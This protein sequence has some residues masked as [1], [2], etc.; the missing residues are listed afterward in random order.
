M[1]SA[2]PRVSVIIPTY[3]RADFIGEAVESVLKQGFVD[4]ELIVIDDG[5]TDNTRTVLETFTDERLIVHFQPNSG[6]SHARNKGLRQARGEYITFLDSDDVYLP[7]KLAKSVAFLDA[8]SEFGMV[9][10]AG[11]FIDD[12]GRSLHV[13]YKAHDQ[14]SIY[15]KIAFF[16]PLT[17]LLPTVMVR[18]S[19]MAEVGEFDES[20]H[21]FEDTDMWRRIAKAYS[22][23]ALD[24]VTCLIRTHENNELA[25]QDPDVL[26]AA[27]EQYI[28]KVLI[29]DADMPAS[30]VSAGAHRLMRHYGI[31]M[32]TVPS[33]APQGQLLLD[34]SRLYFMPRVSI[35]I[36]VFN[37]SD[38]LHDAIQSAIRQDY[39][40]VEIIVVNDGSE[41]DGKTERIALNYGETVRYISKPNGGV[42]SA[43]NRG[44]K[45]MTG[46]YFTWLSHD[47]LFTPD[48]I[49][50]QVTFLGM[51]PNPD[52]CVVYSD[53]EIFGDAVQSTTIRMPSVRS[54]DF[55][56]FITT[57]NILHGCTLMIP[58][59]AFE[60]AGLF[61]INLKTTQDYD[62]WFRMAQS[63]TF[64]H[65]SETLVRARAHANQGTV[66]MSDLAMRECNELLGGFVEALDAGEIERGTS[67]T[68]VAAFSFIANNLEERGFS[69]AAGRAAY[70]GRQQAL[71]LADE[72]RA[73]VSQPARELLDDLLSLQFSYMRQRLV[74]AAKQAPKHDP[75]PVAVASAIESV[76][77]ALDECERERADLIAKNEALRQILADTLASTSWRL[78]SPLRRIKSWQ[79]R[80]G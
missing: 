78:T 58:R 10:T 72:L 44:I 8:H 49:S 2:A 41:D 29:D 1:T 39:G 32:Q 48:K 67:R 16:T 22:I 52:R 17:I 57:Q 35:I 20:L 79:R 38:Y 63:E 36:P 15:S 40:N 14:G 43:L 27:V 3:N 33:V 66:R 74:P 54:E 28:A 56:Y 68:G 4:F 71:T 62:L 75:A 50:K 23:G 64:L 6:R 47:D 11:S 80:I 77:L 45:E 19:V 13:I 21:R 61:D 42:A 60:R 12:H 31:N 9:Y 46:E 76:K 70:R 53:Y 25:S 30:V 37:G 69:L 73:G 5:S 65:Q 51:Q 59:S 7:G 18:S 34:R 26:A 24:E 55:R